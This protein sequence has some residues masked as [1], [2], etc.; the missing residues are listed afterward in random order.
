MDFKHAIVSCTRKNKETTV[1]FNCSQINSSLKNIDFYWFENNNQG[2]SK[3]YNE[4]LKKYQSK[5]DF[6]HFVHDDVFIYDDFGVLEYILSQYN[7]DISGAAGSSRVI[8]KPPY[9]WHS[10][11]KEG[12]MGI[13][14]HG[15]I[16]QSHCSVFGNMFEKAVIMDGLYMCVKTQNIKNWCFNEKFDYHFYDIA[17]CIDAYKQNLTLGIIPIHLRHEC[18]LYNPLT[19]ICWQKNMK[20]FEECYVRKTNS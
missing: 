5:Y 16:K 7:F 17:S 11:G 19:N 4:I 15:K 3:N 8:I 1:L 13:V 6:I 12:G 9:M 20:I 14:E 18:V 10:M 2:L